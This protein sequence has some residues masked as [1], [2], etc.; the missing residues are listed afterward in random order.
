MLEETKE[1]IRLAKKSLEHR[2]A[3]NLSR[4][5]IWGFS[6]IVI[7]IHRDPLILSSLVFPIVKV[8]FRKSIFL[9]QILPENP[10]LH[11]INDP[12]F[13]KKSNPSESSSTWPVILARFASPERRRKSILLIQCYLRW[14]KPSSEN[15]CGN[16]DPSYQETFHFDQE[17]CRIGR[18]FCQPHP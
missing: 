1:N 7:S 14:W 18:R 11:L 4:I 10:H 9:R 17:K 8:I 16:T 12:S 2:F 15:L 13:K 5:F 3:Q 6:L